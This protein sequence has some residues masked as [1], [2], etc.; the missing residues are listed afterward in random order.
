MAF[1]ILLSFASLL[2][3]EAG[4]LGGA[5]VLWEPPRD[6]TLS[7][8]IW[9]AGGE[10][11]APKPP[12]RFVKE[13]P[14]G[15]NPKILLRDAKGDEWVAKFGEEIHADVFVPRLLHACGYFVP[16]SYFVAGGVVTGVS[17]LKRAKP[18]FSKQGGFVF[19]RFKL[20]DHKSSVKV[21][22]RQWTWEDNP[23]LGTHEL[24]GLKILIMLTSD[25]DTKDAREGEG[26]NVAVFSNKS[27]PG[28]FLYMVDD[29]GGSMGKW[30]SLMQRTT[31]DAAGYEKQTK[32]FIKGVKAGVVEWGYGG[33]HQEDITNGITVED[34]RWLLQ[35][36]GAITDEAIKTGLRA[37]GTSERD[38]KTFSRSIRER[39]R[40]LEDIANTGAGRP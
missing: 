16:T 11:R 8:W 17:G 36:L 24:N 7:D 1:A 27:S 25:W 38:V 22:N 14:H 21:E 5:S 26:T 32:D 28:R 20:R 2:A 29:W 6:I 31:W 18:F 9:G 33:R 10:H 40:Q 15:T 35:Y 39:I 19:A 23:F 13:D 12:F 30:G 34:V 4:E 37:S 3:L